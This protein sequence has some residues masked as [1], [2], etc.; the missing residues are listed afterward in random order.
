[1]AAAPSDASVAAPVVSTDTSTT[2]VGSPGST[3]MRTVGGVVVSSSVPLTTA[4]K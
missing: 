3:R 1:M 2:S 4:V